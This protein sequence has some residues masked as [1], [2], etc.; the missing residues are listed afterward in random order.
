MRLREAALSG[1]HD[2]AVSW[3]AEA[4]R[5]LTEQGARSLL[6]ICD[7]DEALM[8]ARRGAPGDVRGARPLLEAA[9]RQFE[10][11]GMTGWIR[12]AEE[13]GEHLG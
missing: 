6:A 5:V 4:R 12:R 11:M 10:V 2:E 13:L 7:Y 9:R 3:F 8:Y 1:R